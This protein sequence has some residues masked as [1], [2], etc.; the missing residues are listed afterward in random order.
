M[1]LNEIY[2]PIRRELNQVE[3]VLELSLRETKNESILRLNRFLLESPGKRLRPA[4]LILSARATVGRSREAVSRELINLACAIEL[5]HIA[6]LV[7]DDVIDHSAFRHNNPTVNSRWGADVSIAL[8][9]YLYSLA[10]KLIATCNNTDILD[11]I[12]SATKSMCEGELTQVV[13]RDNLSLLKERYIMIVKKKTAGLFAA[14]CQAGAILSDSPR[15][16]QNALK[17]Y[18]L[19]FGVA[20]QII[21]DYLDIAAPKARLGKSPGQDIA[22]GEMTLPLLNLLKF[23]DKNKRY[24]LENLLKSKTNGC[25][26]KIKAELSNSGAVSRTKKITLSYLNSAKDRLRALSDSEYRKALLGLVDVVLKKG[27]CQAGE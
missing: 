3:K 24:R 15:P 12:S 11:C 10:F 27:F 2:K 8:G 17:A 20:F 4:M 26:K 19:N 6:S 7:H 22:V 9:D 14:S 1:Q 5:I 23:A 18:G 13:E 25:F 16:L 21:D